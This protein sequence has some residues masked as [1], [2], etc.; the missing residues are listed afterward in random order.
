MS[1]DRLA[2]ILRDRFDSWLLL[3]IFVLLAVANSALM[4]RNHEH[5][6]GVENQFEN[7]E[8]DLPDARYWL[9]NT[10]RLWT[11]DDI[12]TW[13]QSRSAWQLDEYR[14]HNQ[15]AFAVF[16]VL[17]GV[18]W[19]LCSLLLSPRLIVTQR[20]LFLI[21]MLAMA[22]KVVEVVCIHLLLESFADPDRNQ[23]SLLDLDAVALI[24]S[25]CT[26]LKLWLILSWFPLFA[27]GL[28]LTVAD[29]LKQQRSPA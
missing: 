10:D 21:P 8:Q 29:K 11:S 15:V 26:A 17:S 22:V 19:C 6:V 24:G 9:F 12:E 28:V 16:L 2:G 27:I 14:L 23:A 3:A 18:L 5:V 20:W 7:I 1:I 4:G 25:L 13:V